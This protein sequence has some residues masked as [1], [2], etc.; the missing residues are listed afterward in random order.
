MFK[1]YLTWP[2]NQQQEVVISPPKKLTIHF[3]NFFKGATGYSTESHNDAGSKPRSKKKIRL[4]WLVY[5]IDKLKKDFAQSFTS[6]ENI[7]S[8]MDS[9][10]EVDTFMDS[11]FENDRK[12]V[13]MLVSGALGENTVPIIHDASQLD[14]I[15]VFCHNKAHHE[16]WTK[17]WSKVK[18]VSMISIQCAKQ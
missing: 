2:W 12:K 17:Q 10:S 16:R 3:S 7:T 1:F 13:I 18:G 14:F 8:S 11:L 6:L 4:M 9:F 5:D 15:F